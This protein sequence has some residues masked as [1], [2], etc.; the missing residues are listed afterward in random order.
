MAMEHETNQAEP[1]RGT[2][3]VLQR[4]LDA[5]EAGEL[6]ASQSQVGALIGAIETLNVL[7]QTTD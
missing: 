3:E 7:Q 1:V 2:R 6:D 4:V 5:I